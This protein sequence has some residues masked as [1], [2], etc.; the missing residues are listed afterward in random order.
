MKN[1]EL[2]K[3][4]KWSYSSSLTPLIFVSFC[5]VVALL[6]CFLSLIRD[7]VN[8]GIMVWHRDNLGLLFSSIVFHVCIFACFMRFKIYISQKE[9]NN[10]H[11]DQG[12]V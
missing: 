5:F 9:K 12:E 1:G 7:I 2:A 10:W 6:I 4:N 11:P 8:F 3:E